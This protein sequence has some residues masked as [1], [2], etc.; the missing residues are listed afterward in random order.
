[1]ANFTL[2]I[3]YDPVQS[4]NYKTGDYLINFRLCAI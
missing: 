3:Q 4:H 1:M 2:M